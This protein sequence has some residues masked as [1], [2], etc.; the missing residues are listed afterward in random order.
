MAFSHPY[1][2][3]GT[4]RTAKPA[5]V[6]AR[7]REMIELVLFTRPGERPMRPTFGSAVHDLV[8]APL[9]AEMA[10]VVQHTIA[11]SLQQWLGHVIEVRQ[12]AMTVATQ[13][14]SLEV[15]VSYA[16]RSD[17]VVEAVTFVRRATP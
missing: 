10:A 13:D 11:G 17:G 7:L 12:V 3:D 4:G 8:F 16:R 14:G 2:I 6:R 5:D 1:R 15:E 9:S